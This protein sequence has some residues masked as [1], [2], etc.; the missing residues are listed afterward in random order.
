MG[1]N[2]F[3]GGIRGFLVLVYTPVRDFSTFPAGTERYSQLW[4]LLV[5]SFEETFSDIIKLHFP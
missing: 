1:R 3:R 5:V 4:F 2:F